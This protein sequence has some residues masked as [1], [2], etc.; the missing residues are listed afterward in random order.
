MTY[1]RYG[2]VCNIRGCTPREMAAIN[3]YFENG[4]VQ[5]LALK[6]AGFKGSGAHVW[7]KEPVR[8]EIQARLKKIERD[9]QQAYD[10]ARKKNK[11]TKEK[12]I[13]EYAKMAFA[14]LS[15][16]R[17]LEV[18]PETG[19]KV[20]CELIQV[21]EHQR[22]IGA[23]I[24]VD[25]RDKKTA[26]DS[27]AKMEGLFVEHLKISDERELIDNLMAGRTRVAQ[28]KAHEPDEHDGPVYENE[29]NPD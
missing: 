1:R 24:P 17:R 13:D 14:P 6:K 9:R 15:Q 5:K 16:G 3:E 8:K 27:L 18:D 19:E 26:L 25:P 22:E 28:L 4:F 12:L 10:Y 29:P 7:Q 2:E 11:I 21:T 20:M 23:D